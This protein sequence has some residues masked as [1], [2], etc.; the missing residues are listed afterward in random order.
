MNNFVSEVD[1][2]DV[3]AGYSSPEYVGNLH[4]KQLPVYFD[5]NR[6]KCCLAGRRGGKSYVNAV[7]LLNGAPG[8]V[9]LYFADT[10]KSAWHIM[11]TV[12]AELNR[13][14][15]LGLKFRRG[16]SEIIEPNG[17]VIRLHGIKDKPAADDLRGQK[18]DKICGDEAQAIDSELLQYAMESVLQ[19][20]IIDSQGRIILN[21]TP[22][23]EPDSSD[24]WY[25]LCG[26]PYSGTLGRWPTYHWT[27]FDNPRMTPQQVLEDILER[28]G[29]T[30]NHPTFQR[31]YL[32]RWVV[33]RGAL[34]YDW[35][36]GINGT[37]VP[38]LGTT[39]LA[40]DLGVSPDPCGFVV[41]R[42]GERPRVH[43]VKAYTKLN[44]DPITVMEEIN[45]LRREWNISPSNI[46]MDGGGL[47]K[48][49]VAMIQNQFKLPVESAP[50]HEKYVKI[51]LVQGMINHDRIV[52]H[53]DSQELLDEWK[54]IPWGPRNKRGTREH[55]PRYKQDLAD[56]CLYGMTKMN[57]LH[58]WVPSQDTRTNDEK[59]RHERFN[60][61]M[62]NNVHRL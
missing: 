41:L 32:A 20:T 35:K 15:S 37:K 49:Y 39:V 54:K 36:R 1:I 56:A 5:T 34:I 60:Q 40:V 12:F 61:I 58:P 6:F 22:G 52:V 53:S 43:I 30:E 7:W 29:W 48:G 18:F 33:D 27:I 13:D 8:K 3:F 50:K 26:D 47:G 25:T 16:A 24:Y 2:Y 23:F 10:I 19:P 21:G 31:E 51:E 45:K 44:L 59:M 14:F 4:N 17:H 62:N 57:Q 55:H 11:H 9:S 46:V 28:N 42:M 38:S